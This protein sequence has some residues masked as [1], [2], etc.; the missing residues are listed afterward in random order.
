ML[1][2]LGACL[3]LV[4]SV[5]SHWYLFKSS[6]ECKITLVLV[7]TIHAL[8]FKPVYPSGCLSA[9]LAAF[10]FGQSRRHEHHSNGFFP[11][12]VTSF[13]PRHSLLGAALRLRSDDP[14]FQFAL[15]QQ[16]VSALPPPPPPPPRLLQRE[17]LLL[18]PPI[19]LY[20]HY[21]TVGSTVT[22]YICSIIILRTNC[23]TAGRC[24]IILS[25]LPL[26]R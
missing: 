18:V 26:L 7:Y 1:N 12:G 6:A 13:L 3:S 8:V 25:F 11:G 5:R 9:R 4:L 17:V 20:Q 2:C 21:L 24:V 16:P 15:P 19:V 23:I 14:R 22:T 10:S